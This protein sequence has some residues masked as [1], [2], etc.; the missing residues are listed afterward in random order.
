MKSHA[1]WTSVVLWA[2][3][4]IAGSA[5]A[6]EVRAPGS[7]AGVTRQLVEQKDALVKLLLADS[8][9]VQRVE[10]SGNAEA[11]KQLAAARDAYARAMSALKNNDLHGADKQLNDAT[12]LIGKARQLAPD[13]ATRNIEHRVRYAQMQESVESLKATYQRH[14][15]RQRVQ[16]TSAA[17][18]DTA[19][20]AASRLIDTAKSQANAEQLEQANRTL[21]EAERTLMVNISR[22]LGT[23]TVEYA[24][25]FESPSEEYGFELDRNRSYTE[26]IPVALGEFK[27]G[28]EAVRQVNYFVETNRQMRALAQQH[29]A[30]KD[31]KEALAALRGGTGYLQSALAAA[32]LYVPQDLKQDTAVRP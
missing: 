2:C 21:G 4:W 29:A 23:R 18:G 5:S 7:V 3:T 24:L 20:A 31:Y 17:A 12:W 13:P 30:K 26:L 19:L 22:V 28:S 25:R 10:A 14:L 32:G 11:R 8:P 9:A 16:P 1:V 6:A 15:Q 27:P